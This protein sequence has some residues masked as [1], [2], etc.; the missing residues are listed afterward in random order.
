MSTQRPPF[1]FTQHTIPVQASLSPYT[2]TVDTGSSVRPARSPAQNSRSASCPRTNPLPEVPSMLST[3]T[4]SSIVRS[5]PIYIAGYSLAPVRR[6]RM[7]TVD[8]VSASSGIRGATGWR[9]GELQLSICVQYR[10]GEIGTVRVQSASRPP[11]P[12]TSPLPPSQLNKP[13][14]SRTEDGVRCAAFH[15]RDDI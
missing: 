14:I 8:G 5:R 13:D 1:S 10:M 4:S 3:V 9:I 15:P 6:S 11:S 7:C 2:V 12:A